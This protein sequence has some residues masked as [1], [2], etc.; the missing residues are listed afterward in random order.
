MRSPEQTVR[1][2]IQHFEQVGPD[3]DAMDAVPV[4]DRATVSALVEGLSSQ[5]FRARRACAQALARATVERE[6]AARAV[7]RLLDDE[8]E[9]VQAAAGMA[10]GRLCAHTSTAVPPLLQILAS[11]DESVVTETLEGLLAGGDCAS[12][13]VAAH[14]QA[15]AR[16]EGPLQPSADRWEP[17]FG[18]GVALYA[19][20]VLAHF[21]GD[22]TRA[23]LER[24]L[25]F[26]HELDW[27]VREA[28]LDSLLK[29]DPSAQHSLSLILETVR[30]RSKASDAHSA[31]HEVA[32]LV[33]KLD[34]T[35]VDAST[36]VRELA[37]WPLPTYTWD[38]TA[39]LL[40]DFMRQP[41]L[42]EAA[43]AEVAA[44]LDD[45]RPGVRATCVALLG[46][47]GPRAQK[48]RDALVTRLGAGEP[49]VRTAAAEALGRLGDAAPHV[50]TALKKHAQA[51]PSD[52]EGR[53]AREALEQL[54]K[55]PP[56]PKGGTDAQAVM[57]AYLPHALCVERRGLTVLREDTWY[58]AWK[59]VLK[60]TPEGE[61]S[62]D[63]ERLGVAALHLPTQQLELSALPCPLPRRP[64]GAN[65][66]KRWLSLE[67]ELDGVLVCRLE[68]PFADDTG[69]GTRNF[70]FSFEPGSRT[71]FQFL[72]SRGRGGPVSVRPPVDEQAEARERA[73]SGGELLVWKEGG[74]ELTFYSDYTPYFLD[75][76]E[77]APEVQ[78][79][80]ARRRRAQQAQEH[81]H[82][83][84]VE[85]SASEP[86]LLR[87]P[88]E[89]GTAPVR[90]YGLKRA[91]LA[92]DTRVQRDALRA[93]RCLRAAHARLDGRR[94][95]VL[96][97]EL[98]LRQQPSLA[99]LAVLELEG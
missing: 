18:R 74:R 51:H 24:A 50:L 71:W 57:R 62:T 82:L 55:P 2:L 42:S 76:Y 54:D 35:R 93:I 41:T 68:R 91:V 64:T 30:Q 10:L 61:W 85:S 15:L 3:Y 14:V 66:A 33:R 34:P 5:E 87:V 72:P 8:E 97:L 65:G 88:G 31:A 4:E 67:A 83:L 37:R 60:A 7:A 45:K 92:Q 38:D 53:A 12:P 89:P 84:E 95:A 23:A 90:L 86:W 78:E 46:W 69:W 22:A 40:R 70:V 56:L 16:G 49:K 44:G 52:E 19:C 58:F 96:A 39:P 75:D 17:D 26:K 47:A 11:H 80:T 21:P 81:G 94:F 99:A 32:G 1:Q 6:T 36:V 13:E 43:L 48:W 73:L 77:V 25:G 27:R 29:L 63:E 98:E 79:A 28:A 9:L 20:Q 59:Q